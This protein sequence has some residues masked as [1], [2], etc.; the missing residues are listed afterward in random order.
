MIPK[1][2]L[3]GNNKVK[4]S[5]TLLLVIFLS[6]FATHAKITPIDSGDLLVCSDK[7]N[8]EISLHAYLDLSGASSN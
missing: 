7:N 4:K 2:L 1:N 5:T 8:L 6:I 3:I